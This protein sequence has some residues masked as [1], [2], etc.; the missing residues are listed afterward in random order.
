[1]WRPFL[2][3]VERMK[4]TAKLPVNDH[5]KCKGLVVA[6]GRVIAYDKRTTRGIFLEEDPAQYILKRIAHAVSKL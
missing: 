4:N 6:Y 5:P 1:M 3:P 2:G